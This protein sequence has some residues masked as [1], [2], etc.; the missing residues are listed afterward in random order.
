VGPGPHTIE[1]TYLPADT[2]DMAKKPEAPKPVTWDVY[3]AAHRPKIV[4]SVEAVDADK[5]VQKS[6]AGI[7]NRCPAADR[8]GA[9]MTRRDVQRLA[10]AK[11]L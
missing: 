6:R 2:T 8:G 7:Q 9:A 3:R 5:A 1:P 10:G 11:H 4:G